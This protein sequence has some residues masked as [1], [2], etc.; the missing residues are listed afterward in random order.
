MF[1]IFAPK[2]EHI[3]K[4]YALFMCSPMISLIESA[5]KSATISTAFCLIIIDIKAISRLFRH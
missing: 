1:Y 5:D 3:N 4:A 2:K